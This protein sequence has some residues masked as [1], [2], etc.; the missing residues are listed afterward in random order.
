ML[1]ISHLAS[2]LPTIAPKRFSGNSYRFVDARYLLDH[3]MSGIHKPV[4]LYGFGASQNG[5]RFTVRGGAPTIYLAANPAT[6]VVEFT[7]VGI[8]ASKK[9]RQIDL[10]AFATCP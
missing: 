5:Q 1:S 8:N 2:V 3:V 7:R 4:F 6:A 10:S 9:T